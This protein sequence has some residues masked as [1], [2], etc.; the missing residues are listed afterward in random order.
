MTEYEKVNIYSYPKYLKDS[1]GNLIDNIN[2]NNTY[3]FL[4][5]GKNEITNEQ[6]I[7]KKLLIAMKHSMYDFVI[8]EQQLKTFKKYTNTILSLKDVITYFNS[9]TYLP[10]YIY[11]DRNDVNFNYAFNVYANTFIC[12]LEPLVGFKI[13]FSI[14]HKYFHQKD[15][16]PPFILL[17]KA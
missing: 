9:I 8:N 1:Y 2:N 15:N 3:L 14:I 17:E 10:I 5:D 6:L 12:V 11:Q 4:H 13:K 16:D 7:D